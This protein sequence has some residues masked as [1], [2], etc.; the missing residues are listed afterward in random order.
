VD[1]RKTECD[2]PLKSAVTSARL[3]ARAIRI[4]QSKVSD[5][6]HK[7]SRGVEE[8]EVI[9]AALGATGIDFVHIGEYRATEPA[10]ADAAETLAALAKQYLGVPVIA[11][12][13]L[14][15]PETAVSMLAEGSADIVALGKA[16]LA[17][18]NWPHPVRNNLEFDELPLRLRCPVRGHPSGGRGP[19]PPRPASCR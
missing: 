4:S 19:V 2:S 17:D 14:D 10:F 15:D 6:H 11:N 3:L 8:A 1:Q 13:R 16:A 7:W 5:T 12:G 9:F 18:R